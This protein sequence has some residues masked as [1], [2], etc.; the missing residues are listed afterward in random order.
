MVKIT[1]NEIKNRIRDE[2]QCDYGFIK[3]L[4]ESGRIQELQN[5]FNSEDYSSGIDHDIMEEVYSEYKDYCDS[6][7]LD[8]GADNR[9]N[10]EYLNR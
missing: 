1:K 6:W 5:A 9:N 10:K 4:I 2:L 3:Q 8:Y 7:G